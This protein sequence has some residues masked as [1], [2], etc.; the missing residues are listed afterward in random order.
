NQLQGAFAGTQEGVDWSLTER[1]ALH[2]A[3]QDG[4]GVTTGQKTD[5]DQAF[6]LAALWLGAA[7]TIS[8]LPRPPRAVTRGAWV[9]ATLP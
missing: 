6:T 3:N 9:T 8:D 5:L 2:I 4:L 7:T 1:Q